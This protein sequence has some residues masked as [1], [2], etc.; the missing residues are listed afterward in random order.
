MNLAGI[1]DRGIHVYLFMS[2]FWL[3]V[4]VAF[5]VF[6]PHLPI[7]PTTR[8]PMAG[9][10]LVMFGYNL[11]RWRLGRLQERAR[12]EEEE[13]PPPRRRRDTEDIDPAFDFSDA[14]P[15]QDEKKPPPA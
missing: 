10:A 9:F 8:M 2:G 3:V 4:C 1:G 12:R 11:V 7:D 13:R 6:W 15:R 14:E 5:L